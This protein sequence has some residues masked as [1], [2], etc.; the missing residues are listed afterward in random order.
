MYYEKT[1]PYTWKGVELEVEVGIDFDNLY[2]IK[3]SHKEDDITDLVSDRLEEEFESAIDKILR[4]NA[5]QAKLEAQYEY[6]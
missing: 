1:V 5:Y 3:I 6:N 4:D 2:I